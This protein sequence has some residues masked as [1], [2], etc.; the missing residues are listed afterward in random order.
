MGTSL[1]VR[2]QAKDLCKVNEKQLNVSINFYAELNK[3][4]ESIIKQASERAVANG[5]TT[6]MGKDI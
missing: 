4:V 1:V 3:K 6:V 5:R 2:T